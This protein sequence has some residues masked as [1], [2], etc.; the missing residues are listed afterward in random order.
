MQNPDAL[1]ADAFLSLL[2]EVYADLRNVRRDLRMDD[3]IAGGLGIDSLDA[4]ELLLAL[5]VRYGVQLVSNPQVAAVVT[6][7]D[8]FELLTAEVAAKGAV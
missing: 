6:V 3:V 5:E 2:E 1:N 8:L 4:L 7:R